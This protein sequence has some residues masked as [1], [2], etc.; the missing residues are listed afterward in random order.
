MLFRS[1]YWL[2]LSAY[3][4]DDLARAKSLLLETTTTDPYHADAWSTFATVLA[5]LGDHGGA[6]QAAEKTIKLDPE[7]VDAYFV[8]GEALALR[9]RVREAKKPL[10]EYIRRAGPDGDRTADARALLKRR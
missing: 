1:G 6:A 2:A 9:R 3:I 10:E 8:L 5:E 4:G 7:N